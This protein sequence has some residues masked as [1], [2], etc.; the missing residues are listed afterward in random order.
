[1]TRTPQTSSLFEED[2]FEKKGAIVRVLLPL[3]LPQAYD[4]R[5]PVSLMVED[6]DFVVVPLGPRQ[7]VGVVWGEGL[8][9]IASSR[10]KNIIEKLPAPPL[11]EEVRKFVDWVATYTMTPPGMVLR[12]AMRA[13]GALEPAAMRRA[14][15]LAGPPPVRLTPARKRVL[16]VAADGFARRAGELAEEAGVSNGVIKG[17]ADA[18]TLEKVDL[19]SEAPF[20]DPDSTAQQPILSPEQ[21]EV[22]GHLRA[23]IGANEFSATLLDGVT[24]SGKTEVYFEA[25]AE[26]IEQ[27]RQVMILVPEIAL[28]AQFLKRFEVR[29][30]C[31]PAQW[32]SDL[33]SRERRRVW[34]GVAEDRVKVV[35]G[36]RSALF[37][38][39]PNLGLIIV[40]EEHE[41]AFKQDEGVAYNARDMC[42]VRASLGAFPV[43]LA[44]ATPSLETM[45]NVWSGRYAHE[46]LP[47]RHGG[48]VL[49]TIK[50]I[51]MRQ[52]PP[53]RG[54]W[55]SPQLVS[56]VAETLA[57]DEQALLFLN[58]RGY[59]P[60]TLC[61]T[62]G[63]RLGC[64]QCDAWLV[65]HRFRKQLQ[66]H[67]CGYQ[68][69]SPS[70]CP[71]CGGE[72]SL[73]ACGPGV[74]RIMEEVKVSFPDARIALLS[75][76]AL[77][78]PAAYSEA[79]RQIQD[80]EIDLIVGTQIVAKG[81][82]FPLLTLVGVVDADLGLENG[83]LRAGERTYQLLHQ[84][85][86]RAGR[87]QKPGRVLMQTYMPE[88]PVMGAL[89]SGDRDKF[90]ER[91]ARGREMLG[92]PPY[93]RLVALVLSGPELDKV[94]GLSRELALR[95]PHSDKVSVLGPAPA[96][97]SL[98]RGRHRVRFLVKATREAHVQGF[99]AQ[100]LEGVKVPSS[101]RLSVD[102]DPHN[103][104]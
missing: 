31:L 73:V 12:L 101:M 103:F 22:A 4:Y 19:P 13:P 70:A 54:K 76:D 7:L 72:D 53:E 47:R 95:V 91:E 62:C 44:T 96:P 69:P 104:L 9:D 71:D 84:V 33:S 34:R 85:A 80:H 67:H 86:G 38:P 10:I 83:D 17:L 88:H 14:Y 26:A 55:L 63:H 99:V 43:V 82:N 57:R 52:Y 40:D 35:V 15:R 36:A 3:G 20:E 92:Y 45:S 1:M 25:V 50:P 89:V 64:P 87:A 51:D 74:E 78:G 28:T 18:G 48:A 59:A 37:L 98:L 30:G 49:P 93:G 24:G 60:L 41:N 77:R 81:L 6:G 90:L 46:V 79:I 23:R 2:S 66:C 42:V 100:W 11:P 61:R 39:Y 75:S 97:I 58:R 5:V 29:F 16:E 32:H 56:A 21:A 65:E 68:A 8:G 102:V 27:N 94:Q